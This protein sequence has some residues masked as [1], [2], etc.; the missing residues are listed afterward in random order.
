MLLDLVAEVFPV[1]DCFQIVDQL[2]DLLG[3][4]VCLLRGNV[5]EVPVDLL[6]LELVDHVV[7]QLV[8]GGHYLL[9]LLVEFALLL[10]HSLLEQA[11]LGSRQGRNDR[12]VD[13]LAH[14]FDDFGLV[15]PDLDRELLAD[16]IGHHRTESDSELLL[17]AASD[18][19]LER[20]D[21]HEG[22]A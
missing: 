12:G 13:A 18:L 5:D 10:V 2:F 21:L 20:R 1:G 14:Y 11:A 7:V 17:L 15:V 9:V 4:D 19:A 22:F 8:M 6:L 3:G 16:G